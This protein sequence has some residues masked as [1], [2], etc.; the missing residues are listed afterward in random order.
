MSTVTA[1]AG[2]R[3]PA[4]V[5][6]IVSSEVGERFCNNGINAILAVY[7]VQFLQVGEAQATTWQALFKSGAFLFPLL[8]AVVSDVLTGPDTDYKNYLTS[9][10]AEIN[11]Q[12]DA[13]TA[14]SKALET[15][16]TSG[17]EK[18]QYGA[19]LIMAFKA[20]QGGPK[21]GC[22]QA[23]KLGA[24]ELMFGK[25]DVVD[26]ALRLYEI[27][28]DEKRFKAQMEFEEKALKITTDAAR[29]ARRD[30]NRFISDL[31]GTRPDEATRSRA[32]AERLPQPDAPN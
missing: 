16:L 28:R 18:T 32:E 19:T 14:D 6:Y 2:G 12:S 13:V 20:G 4:G 1:A 15:A 23:R 10:R 5:P 25:A 31:A 3:M 7:M 29:D 24:V 9:C 11:A 21:I 27:N 22:T 17:S 8:G 30:N 26:K